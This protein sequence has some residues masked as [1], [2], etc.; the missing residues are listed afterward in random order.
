M[1]HGLVARTASIGAI[2]P[3]SNIQRLG[4]KGERRRFLN[5]INMYIVF[6]NYQYMEQGGPTYKKRRQRHP[7][8]IARHGFEK[9]ANSPVV[10][11]KQLLNKLGKP[12]NV[13][14]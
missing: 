11:D 6:R 5:I 10:I 12:N 4:P 2:C 8:R 14:V 3:K 7:R 9:F 1:L 13:Y